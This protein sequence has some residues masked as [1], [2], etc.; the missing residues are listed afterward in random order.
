MLELTLNQLAEVTTTAIL[1]KEKPQIFDENKQV[2]KRGGSVAGNARKEIEA[3]TGEPV[4]TS[5]K[6]VDFARLLADVVESKA[7][8]TDKHK[9]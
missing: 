4:I 3:Q 5:K 7:E 9:E 6:A 2:A 8:D 1:K